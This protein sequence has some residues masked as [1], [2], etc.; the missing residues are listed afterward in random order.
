MNK[1]S[2]WMGRIISALVVLFFLTDAIT[3]LIPLQQ[4]IDTMQML[5]FNSTPALARALAAIIIVEVVLYVIPRTSIAGAVLLTGYLGGAIAT[6]LRV[7]APLLTH[8]LFGAY[9]GIAMWLGLFLRDPST[10]VVLRLNTVA[11]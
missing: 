2:T 1:T 8:I 11:R 4:V 7:E 3:K 6:Q 5:G 9:V 10:T